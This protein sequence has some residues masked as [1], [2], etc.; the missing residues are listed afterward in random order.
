[1]KKLRQKPTLSRPA[2]NRSEYM[3]TTMKVGQSGQGG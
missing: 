3:E 2:N 1:M